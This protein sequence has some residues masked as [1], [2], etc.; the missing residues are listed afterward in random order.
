MRSHVATQQSC[1]QSLK[2]LLNKQIPTVRVNAKVLMTPRR[3]YKG[4][5]HVQASSQQDA[6]INLP[7]PLPEPDTARAA[8][9]V[10]LKLTEANRW[11]EAQ[12]Y[13]ERALNLPGTGIKRFRDKPP[14]LS[15]GERIACMFNLACCQSRLGEE[16]N[17]QNGLMA[18]AGCLE[19]GY[20]NWQ[21]L[22]SDPD[23]E[24]L[25]KSEKFEGLMKKFERKTGGFG[26][27]FKSQ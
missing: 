14:Q 10:G 16:E 18:I 23:L 20:D 11:E 8:I 6:D 1:I 24:N 2:T 7:S 5:V 27:F 4:A 3:T 19:A 13:F 25:R 17:I 12:D 22:R 15:D 9:A 26:N 21:Q